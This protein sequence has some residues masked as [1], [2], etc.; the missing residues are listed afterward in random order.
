MGL[1]LF[2]W[3]DSKDKISEKLL[4]IELNDFALN[5][6]E[7]L[8]REDR[9]I[10]KIVAQELIDQGKLDGVLIGNKGW[11]LP[12][13]GEKFDIIWTKLS[14][15]PVNL[16]E[17]GKSWGLNTKRVYLALSEYS[18]TKT[19]NVSA[20]VRAKDQ[21][22]LTSY[23]KQVWFDSL[24][25]FDL[26]DNVSIETVVENTVIPRETKDILIK[27]LEK[28]LSEKRSDIILGKDRILRRREDLYLILSK[29]IPKMF[30][31]G[32]DQIEFSRLADKYG[33]TIEEIAMILQKLLDNKELAD[34]TIYPLDNYISPKMK[35]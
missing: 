8:P 13:T 27:Q 25:A 4:N 9:S 3:K 21:I 19:N 23:L 32:F 6:I 5:L 22:F 11:F 14:T 20:F 1:R 17:V 28:W 35:L 16:N 24:T 26:N 30:E 12:K 34:I 33:V 2:S 15:G 7:K 10:I 29:D 31:E 18:K